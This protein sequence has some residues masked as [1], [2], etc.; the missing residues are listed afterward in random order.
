MQHDII[1]TEG[2]LTLRPLSE[3]DIPQLCRLAN[4]CL[5]E[6]AQMGAPPN[7]ESYYQASL[8]S[9]TEMPFVIVVDGELAGS[10]RYGGIREVHAG[11]EIGWTWLHPRWH[12]TG[13]NRRM[14][15]LLLTH[16]FEQMKMERVQLRTD[17]RNKRSQ[18]AMEK[19]G[20]AKEGVLRAHMRRPDGSMRDTVLFSFIQAE[21][22]EVKQRLQE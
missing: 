2:N 22:P 18:R 11:L 9:V 4:E 3:S 8:T 7:S 10:T 5:E 20:A 21:W 1:L 16:A 17:I 6:L 15:L 19:I 13:V 14:K 12:G